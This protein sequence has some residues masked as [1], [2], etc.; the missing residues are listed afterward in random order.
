MAKK[1]ADMTPMERMEFIMVGSSWDDADEV[2]VEILARCMALQT[3]ARN[4]GKPYFESLMTRICK[5][6]DEWVHENNNMVRLAMIKEE[7]QILNRE[8]N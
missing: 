3:Y 5:R 2:G 7:S 1:R 8:A 4:N 6:A